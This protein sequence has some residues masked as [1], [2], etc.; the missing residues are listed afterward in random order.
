[1]LCTVL[2]VVGLIIATLAS[3]LIVFA[4][5]MF[6]GLSCVSD[7]WPAHVHDPVLASPPRTRGR[8]EDGDD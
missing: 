8:G 7:R 2:A 6:R 4:V 3:F 5:G 1:M